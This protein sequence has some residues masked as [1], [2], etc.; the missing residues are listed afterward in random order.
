LARLN[1][2]AARASSLGLR[3]ICNF[4]INV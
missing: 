4:E 2:V 3:A 1:L